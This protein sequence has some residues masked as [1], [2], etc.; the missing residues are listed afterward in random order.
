MSGRRTRVVNQESRERDLCL[1][2][3]QEIMRF[4]HWPAELQS[5]YILVRGRPCPLTADYTGFTERQRRGRQTLYNFAWAAAV[6]Y[7]D[8]G[9]PALE[10]V[11][12]ALEDGL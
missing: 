2:L 6:R 10:V 1:G 11:A 9:L 4:D 8:S 3:M 7:A 12:R 5:R